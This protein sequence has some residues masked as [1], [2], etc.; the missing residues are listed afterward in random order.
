MN[1]QPG[2]KDVIAAK[3]RLS[4]VNGEAGEL[5]IAGIPLQEYAERA[6]FEETIHLLWNGRLPDSEEMNRLAPICTG[7][8]VTKTPF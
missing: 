1:F 3:T 5:V 4:S 2:L 8:P 7:K 6:T